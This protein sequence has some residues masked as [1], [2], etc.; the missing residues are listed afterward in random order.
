MKSDLKYRK[1][2]YSEERKLLTDAIEIIKRHDGDASKQQSKLKILD[3][4]YKIPEDEDAQETMDA[5]DTTLMGATS[6]NMIHQVCVSLG[7]LRDEKREFLKALLDL[8]KSVLSI[9]RS[10]SHLY[11]V[12]EITAICRVIC[13]QVSPH[14][15]HQDLKTFVEKNFAEEDEE[16]SDSEEAENDEEDEDSAPA[17]DTEDKVAEEQCEWILSRNPDK[18]RARAE[19][20]VQLFDSASSEIPE[21][22]SRILRLVCKSFY[23]ISLEPEDTY[24]CQRQFLCVVVARCNNSSIS[25]ET[26]RTHPF[27]EIVQLIDLIEGVIPHGPNSKEIQIV[28]REL[29]LDTLCFSEIDSNARD[30]R[31][32]IREVLRCIQFPVVQEEFLNDV[33]QNMKNPEK[34]SWPSVGNRGRHH[35]LKD[36]ISRVQ[37]YIRSSRTSDKKLNEE[38]KLIMEFTV[39]TMLEIRKIS[40]EISEAS[41]EEAKEILEAFFAELRHNQCELRTLAE[42]RAFFASVEHLIDAALKGEETP[43][44]NSE[45][46]E[47]TF[48]QGVIQSLD[49]THLEPAIEFVREKIAEIDRE[50]ALKRKYL[51]EEGSVENVHRNRTKKTRK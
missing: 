1:V 35:V 50:E 32:L 34:M 16:D 42:E 15:E 39:D 23:C 6:V 33:D 5:K 21:L 29:Q 41:L 45:S 10:V 19:Q 48:W 14:D 36:K 49:K 12:D 17:P 31:D 24:Q 26:Y 9:K 7:P 44:E 8:I 25:L 11:L 46:F 47:V 2:I 38:Y 13:T 28:T 27:P 18:L 4:L 3:R 20:L 51:P 22:F 40:K 37:K 43:F 30:F